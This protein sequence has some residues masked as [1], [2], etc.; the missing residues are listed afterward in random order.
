MKLINFILV[1]IVFFSCSRS[2]NN[3][4]VTLNN[5]FLPEYTFDT[6]DLINLNLPQF[7]D[8]KFPGNSIVLANENIGINGIVIYYVG[9]NVYNAFE[10]T[11]P[12]HDMYE[13]SFLTVDGTTATCNCEEQNKYDIVSGTMAKGTKGQYALKRYFVEV[14]GN[15]IRVYNN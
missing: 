7:S 15:I 5:P 4:E 14:N 10:L 8:L 11:D 1:A 9:N 6:G 2:E 3:E 13:C 12:N